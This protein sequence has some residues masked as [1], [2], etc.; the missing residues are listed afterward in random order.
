MRKTP[1]ALILI[2][3]LCTGCLVVARNAD[4]SRPLSHGS[5]PGPEGDLSL[6]VGDSRSDGEGMLEGVEVLLVDDQGNI[7][8]LGHTDVYGWLTLPKGA[9]AKGRVL[10]FV[11]ERYFD[12]AWRIDGRY[13]EDFN[14]LFIALAPFSLL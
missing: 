7:S 3:S 10:I 4:I 13:L 5:R 2:S 1:A 8:S 11:K 9:I 12:G 6:L 14:R